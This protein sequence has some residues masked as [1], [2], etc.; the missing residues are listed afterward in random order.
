MYKRQNQDFNTLLAAGNQKPIGLWGDGTTLW[1]ADST[2]HKLYA[3]TISTKA[4]DSS[5]DFDTLIAAGNNDP[6]GLWSDG[7]YMWVTDGEDDKIYAYRMPANATN[8]TPG[9]TAFERESTQDFNTLVASGNIHPEGL[10][11]DGT[12]MWVLDDRT[13]KIHAYIL[14]TKEANP[15]RD[16]DT[17]STIVNGPYGI[18]SNGTTLWISLHDP[19]NSSNALLW[20][21]SHTSEWEEVL[22]DR[23]IEDF[24]KVGNAAT[25]PG[26][27]VSIAASGF[28]GNLATTDNDVQ[29][30]AQKLDDLIV[31]SG[32]GGPTTAANVSVASSGFDGNLATTDN[33]VQKVA[34]KLDD[35]VIPTGGGGGSTGGLSISDTA[36]TTPSTGDLWSD[37]S[38]DTLN[39]RV[40]KYG[41]RDTTK[42]F[43][44]LQAAGNT[45]LRGIWTNGTYMWVVDFLD[46]K[47]YA[48]NVSDKSRAA[49]QDFNTNTL[50]GPTHNVPRGLWS[51]GTTM[52]T[53]GPINGKVY[54]YNLSTK[55][56]DASKDFNTLSAVP[57][58][59]WSDGTYMW[60]SNGITPTLYAYRM[61]ANATNATPGGTA[62]ARESTQDITLD[63]GNTRPVGLWS[64]GTTMWVLDSSDRLVYAYNL[65]TGDRDY[66]REINISGF[67]EPSSIT[68][69]GTTTWVATSDINTRDRILVAF[70]HGTPAWDR[71]PRDDEVEDFA[72]IGSGAVVPGVK[73]GFYISYSAPADPPLGALWSNTNA[74]N[75]QI[76]KYGLNASNREFNTL[77]G[78]GNT[79]PRGLWR[80]ST[81][82]V[83]DATQDKIYSYNSFTKANVPSRD[84]NTLSAAGNN[85]PRGLW[86]DGTYMWVADYVDNK[87]YAYNLSNKSRVSSQDF[88]T[89]SAAGNNNPSDI[90]SDGTTMYV[91]DDVDNK[92]YAYNLS[93]KARDATKDF[94]SS[95]L[96]LNAVR[97]ITSDGN[98]MWINNGSGRA[99]QAYNL[100]TKE[101]D[102]QKNINTLRAAGNSAGHGIHYYDSCLLYTSPSPRD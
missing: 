35:L 72:K 66:I 77:T 5:K 39:L 92:I 61:P 38:K 3:Y 21:Y 65:S 1:V 94:E 50:A 95:L 49:S 52:W 11:S 10:W 54:A 62:F 9:G 63:E 78:A 88:N 97:G 31:S 14:S 53:A 2:D 56:H 45:N 17:S 40:Q 20:G 89:L 79:Q 82:Y 23:E 25:V 80:N 100:T 37:T 71:V 6:R 34:Q 43:D 86:S 91:A 33:S 4:R 64:D 81:M 36:P 47:I 16:I 58:G 15:I 19:D 60:I 32:G 44:T 93:T 18:W 70:E 57:E 69:D 87:I 48:Y 13:H 90:W 83:S 8:A 76:L 59:I 68:S 75:L 99:I 101:R 73:S 102:T 96:R 67:G 24:A 22:R 84:F 55:A 7:T 41:I 27:K 85:D 12:Y 74:G 51:D 28:D 46:T 29:K 98:T 42:D 26:T 30:V